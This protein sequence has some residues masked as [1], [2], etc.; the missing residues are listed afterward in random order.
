MKAALT[1]AAVT[2]VKTT[3]MWCATGSWAPVHEPHNTCCDVCLLLLC[4]RRVVGSDG[5]TPALGPDRPTSG[6]CGAPIRQAALEFV[7]TAR[8]VGAG[9][10]HCREFQ[11]S[12]DG[13]MSW[14]RASHPAVG[15]WQYE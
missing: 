3:H 4:I 9:V 13:R 5:V 11:G 2:S 6:I 8:Q 7:R 14:H 15:L 1:L 12:A 10:I